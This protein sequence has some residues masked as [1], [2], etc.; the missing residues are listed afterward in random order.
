[1]R[2]RTKLSQF[3][4]IF[5]PTLRYAAVRIA[6]FLVLTLLSST[7][8]SVFAFVEILLIRVS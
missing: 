3:L 7:K 8:C 1:M 6:L 4:R 2:S 5:L